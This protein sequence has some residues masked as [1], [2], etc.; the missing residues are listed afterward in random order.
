MAEERS[1]R[2]PRRAGGNVAGGAGGNAAG[3]RNLLGPGSVA[4]MGRAP[5]GG[6]YKEIGKSKVLRFDGGR[7]MA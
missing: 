7:Q 4:V 6:N 3:G 5:T 2:S 1:S